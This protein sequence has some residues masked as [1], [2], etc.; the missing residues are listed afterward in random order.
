MLIAADNAGRPVAS[1]KS[2]IPQGER[3]SSGSDQAYSGIVDLILAG[4]LRPG[5]RTSLGLLSERLKIG[6]APVKEAITRLQADGILSVA[7]RSGTT[8]KTMNA[9]ETAQLMALSMARSRPWISSN[10]RRMRSCGLSPTWRRVF[11]RP[12]SHSMIVSRRVV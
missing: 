4:D 3:V 12:R 6:R 5:E 11:K 7:N 1:K 9:A 10:N 2:I 8:L